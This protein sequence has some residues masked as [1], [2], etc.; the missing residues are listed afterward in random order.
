VPL[1]T[2]LQPLEKIKTL[3]D[4]LELFIVPLSLSF[5]AILIN[6]NHQKRKT[7]NAENQIREQALQDY[8]Q[9][10]STFLLEQ[11][12]YKAKKMMMFVSLQWRLQT[13]S[14]GSLMVGEK[15]LS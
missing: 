15:E 2:N 8:I 6:Q 11:N 3:W 1:Q 7:Q 4:W 12:L 13:I 5:V 10:M 9:K 14:W